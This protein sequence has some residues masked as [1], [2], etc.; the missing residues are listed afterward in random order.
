MIK[1]VLPRLLRLCL[2]PALSP[3]VSVPMQRLIGNS[4]G[5]LLVPALN[6]V[7]QRQSIG[8]V[9]VTIVRPKGDHPRNVVIYLHGGGYVMGGVSS[10]GRLAG[11]LAKAANAEVWLVDY[12]LAP[13]HIFPAALEDALAVYTHLLSIG[14]DPA[15]ITIAGD[16]AG[17]GLTLG[18]ATAIRDAALPLPAA[19]VLISPW[20][21]LSLAGDSHRTHADRD[22]MLTPA[23]LTSCADAYRGSLPANNP[24]CSPLFANLRGLPP[25]LIQVGSEEILLSDSEQLFEAARKV[26]LKVEL[27][28]FDGMWHVFQLHAGMLSE[29][30]R[31]LRQIGQFISQQTFARARMT[32][33][34]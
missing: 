25:I 23:W 6:T 10:H 9:S 4:I 5:Q 31:A 11:H 27:Q 17:G 24:N 7:S 12:R 34:S 18:T 32:E 3:N 15:H 30:D 13:E 33:A 8:D 2:K 14:K 26:K 29:S 21:D 22:P 28:R 19:L 20:I 1:A 16:S